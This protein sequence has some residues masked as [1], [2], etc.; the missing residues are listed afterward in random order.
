MA[1]QIGAATVIEGGGASNLFLRDRELN[2]SEDEHRKAMEQGLNVN[3]RL[4]WGSGPRDVRVLVSDQ[5]SGRTGSASAFV[6]VHDLASGAFFLSSILAHG[7]AH[8][9]Q[10][11]GVRIFREG[12]TVSFVYHIYNAATDPAD[13][14][15][16]QVQSRIFAGGLEAFSGTPSTVDFPAA[17]DTKRRQVTGRY[18]LGATLRP[19][20]YIFAVTVTDM[21]SPQPRT[22]GQ[23]VDFTVE[24]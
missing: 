5:R 4:S 17:Q 20:R 15:R 11:A 6:Q 2:L 10:V 16:V 1:F 8:P 22:A 3:F 12:E 13:T 23:F 7:D 19:G 9:R 21:L 18:Q 14:S 24:P